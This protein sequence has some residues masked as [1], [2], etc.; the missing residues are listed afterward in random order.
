[1]KGKSGIQTKILR[2]KTKKNENKNPGPENSEI[3]TK[4]K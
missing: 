1:L 3:Q 4:I 2:I